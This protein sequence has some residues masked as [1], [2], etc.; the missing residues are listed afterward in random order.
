MG[1]RLDFCTLTALAQTRPLALE[2]AKPNNNLFVAFFYC[3][4]AD[5]NRRNIDIPLNLSVSGHLGKC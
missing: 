2:W 5:Q 1:L 4:N 3:A